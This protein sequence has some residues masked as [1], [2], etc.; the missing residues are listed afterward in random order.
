MD[1]FSKICIVTGAASGLGEGISKYLLSKN[2]IVIL[3]DIDKKRLQDFC[4]NNKQYIGNFEI[5]VID[6]T[7][8]DE[9]YKSIT[10][11]NNK[12]GQIDYLFNNAGIGGTLPF[13]QATIQHWNKIVSLNLFGIV[14]GIQITYPL[15][16]KQNYGNIINTSSISG[17]I[18]FQGQTLY[19]TTKFAIT[20]LT[21]SLVREARKHNIYI[22]AICPGM[23]KT[24][25]FYKPI[26]GEEAS[27]IDVVIPKE[28]IS[29]EQAV[30]DIFIGIEKKKNIII[31][32]KILRKYYTRY[33]L[34]GKLP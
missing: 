18:P 11:I 15:M 14:N 9:M 17:L 24:R 6:V 5:Q 25:I 19:N 26:I 4:E 1:L 29:V 12:Y 13:E 34:L 28:A 30:K 7:S 8:Y 23:V 27:E 16:L 2:A 31:T 10:E 3:F 21:L 22:C 32:P 33:R 20:G